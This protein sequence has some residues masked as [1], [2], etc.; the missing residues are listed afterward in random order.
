MSESTLCT[1]GYEGLA[2]GA[3]SM[4]QKEED[5]PLGKGGIPNALHRL[6]WGKPHMRGGGSRGGSGGSQRRIL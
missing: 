2:Q 3:G 4:A 5:C 6:E 1:G